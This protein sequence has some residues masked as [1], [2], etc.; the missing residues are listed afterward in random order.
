VL[1]STYFRYE[2]SIKLVMCMLRILHLN[3]DF[4]FML[5][6]NNVICNP[7]YAADVFMCIDTKS[8]TCKS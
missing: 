4:A 1:A 3:I 7:I 2:C 8:I 6:L 5:H